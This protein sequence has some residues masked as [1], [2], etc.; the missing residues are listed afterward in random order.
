M[1]SAAPAGVTLTDFGSRVKLDNGIV[2]ATW[3]KA[4]AEMTSLK[5]DGDELLGNGGKGYIQQTF[6]DRYSNPS[7]AAYALERDDPGLKGISFTW[8]VSG[9]EMELHYVMREND[10]GIYSYVIAGYNSARAA[11]TEMH[12]F[13]LALRSDPRIFTR[14]YVEDDRIYDMPAPQAVAAGTV[15]SPKEAILL[16]DGTIHYKYLYSN[17]IKDLDVLGWTGKGKGLWIISASNEYVNGGPTHQELTV[18]Q[19]TT[20]PVILKHFS[21]GHYGAGTTSFDAADSPWRKLY[22]PYMIY[23][24]ANA[25]D[26]NAMWIDAKNRTAQEKAAWPYNWMDHPLYP[27]TFERGTMTGTLNITDGSSPAGALVILAQP[28]DGTPDTNWQRQGKDYIFW[29]QASAGGRF[30]IRNV[31]PGT[32]TLYAHVPGVLDEY[33]LHTVTVEAGAVHGLGR[34]DWTPRMH[35]QLIWQIGIPD[36]SAAEYLHGD[37][38]RHFGLW[39]DYPTD[40]PSGV[41]YTIGTS[42]EATDWNFNQWCVENDRGGYDL[43]PWTI[44]FDMAEIVGDQAVLTVAIAAARQARLTVAVNNVVVLRND[45]LLNDS[46]GPRAGIRG[47]YRERIIKFHSSILST[48]RTNTIVLEQTR[49]GLFPSIMYD[50]IRLETGFKANKSSS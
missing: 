48:T 33:Q 31:R 6:D 40:F 41:T 22:G 26:A 35:G 18:H 21:A 4:T 27:L 47:F 38:Y 44:K 45:D 11:I 10:S 39:F 43:S 25:T 8:I 14:A 30:I 36:R 12:Q 49:G 23:L 28:T 42:N 50:C 46:A 1:C 13:N 17:Y 15:L 3:I 24:N 5:H 2:S 34:L 29:T 20:T 9:M 7:G 37:D 19:T 32:Y 16:A